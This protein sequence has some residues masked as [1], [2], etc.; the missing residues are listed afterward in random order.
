MEI[1]NAKH[2]LVQLEENITSNSLY[3]DNQI[4]AKA[5][6]VKT[7]PDQFHIFIDIEIK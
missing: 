6:P 3:I 5:V 2:Y 7:K 1:N 4:P